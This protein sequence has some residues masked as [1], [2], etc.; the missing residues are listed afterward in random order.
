MNSAGALHSTAI[1]L[2]DCGPLRY[3]TVKSDDNSSA[4]HRQS[5]QDTE[6]ACALSVASTQSPRIGLGG[7][8]FSSTAGSA[9]HRSRSPSVSSCGDDV[10]DVDPMWLLDT[11]GNQQGTCDQTL[12]LQPFHEFGR[13]LIR[14]RQEKLE[15]ANV[16]GLTTPA[17]SV[18][19]H[20]MQSL[21]EHMVCFS[22]RQSEYQKR[23]PHYASSD[24][25]CSSSSSEGVTGELAGLPDFCLSNA[26]G[27]LGFDP[28]D[29]DMICFNSRQSEHQERPPHHSSSNQACSSSSSE[30]VLRELA[31]LP[32]FC[33]SCASGELGF[34][35]IA[36]DRETQLLPDLGIPV[37]GVRGHCSELCYSHSSG[38]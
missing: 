32:D 9:S 7:F 30:S 38:Q 12:K 17:L 24:G 20:C 3:C 27:D 19:S 14:Y 37:E 4:S 26:S 21:I 25:A 11:K 6:D 31:H 2:P 35:L 15:S 29:D 13:S 10:D 36:G 33:L 22:S 23:P 34:A 8:V 5:P 18:I 16:L 1:N 28:L